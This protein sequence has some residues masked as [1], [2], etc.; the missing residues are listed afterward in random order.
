MSI[1]LMRTKKKGKDI[2]PVVGNP[3]NAYD[4]ILGKIQ[5]EIPNIPYYIQVLKQYEK[6][7]SE[8]ARYIE[9]EMAKHKRE[10]LKKLTKKVEREKAMNA[11]LKEKIDVEE[12]Y[13]KEFNDFTAKWN[14]K[15]EKFEEKVEE[16]R[17]EMLEHQKSQLQDHLNRIEEKFALRLKDSN[18]AILEMKKREKALAR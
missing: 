17:L 1:P 3:V 10:E 7:C 9:A 12:A 5:I 11:H 8:E 4:I 16:S 15:L 18:N 14:R 13:L 2:E 6:E